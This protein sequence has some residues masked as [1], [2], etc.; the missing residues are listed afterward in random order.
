MRFLVEVTSIGSGAKDKAGSDAYCVEADTWQRALQAARGIRNDNGPMSGFSIEL[1]DEGCRATDPMARLR[2]EVK[3]APDDTPLTE[4]A[5]PSS[6]VPKIAHVATAPASEKSAP[7]KPPPRPGS[8]QP[9]AKRSSTKTAIMGSSGAAVVQQEASTRAARPTPPV[10]PIDHEAQAPAAPAVT[11][12]SSQV[13]FKREEDATSDTP[14]TYREYVYAVAPGTTEA[15]AEQLLRAQLDQVKASLSGS[16]TR[17][18]VNLAAFDVVFK[19]KPPVPPLA[20]LTWKDWRDAPVLGFPRRS[21]RRQKRR[22]RR[23]SR[24][25]PR[26][27]VRSVPRRLRLPRQW[28][29]RP[30]LRL[31]WRPR[32][33]CRSP[34]LRRRRP[35]RPSRRPP[36]RRKRRRPPPPAAKAVSAPPPPPPAKAVASTPPPPQAASFPP[37]AS[38]TPAPPP[39]KAARPP[40]ELTKTIPR[41]PLPL[42]RRRS[43]SRAAVPSKPRERLSGDELIADLFEAM[44]DL[45]FVRDAVEGG[46]FCLALAMDK[47]PCAAGLAHLYDINRREYVVVA[48]KGADEAPR[49]PPPALP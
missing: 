28:W 49:A 4:A 42:D 1:L 38:A 14:L 44:H 46:D 25:R 2:Y 12:V 11:T 17:K 30:H 34:R 35:S 31:A 27:F 39:P 23:R 20:T 18:L 13:V 3:R 40:A 9:P 16:E 33:R 45:H 10:R 43:R 22:Q 15:A 41:L 36:R 48:V 24:S 6:A 19:G 7:S 29:R 26:R 32:Q 47:L 5:A 37:A 21:G 8:D